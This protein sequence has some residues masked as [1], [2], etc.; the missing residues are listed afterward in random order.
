MVNYIS[1]TKINDKII[2]ISILD[3]DKTLGTKNMNKEALAIFIEKL[4]KI[5]TEME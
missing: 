3:S 5:Y 4:A 2:R 1:V